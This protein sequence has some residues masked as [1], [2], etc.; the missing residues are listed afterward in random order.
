MKVALQ[1]LGDQLAEWKS[2]GTLPSA[3][4]TQ[5]LFAQTKEVPERTPPHQVH[6]R[7]Y[8][9]SGQKAEKVLDPENK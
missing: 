3:G 8:S 4:R 2:K 6:P 1:P 7:D 5:V 9:W